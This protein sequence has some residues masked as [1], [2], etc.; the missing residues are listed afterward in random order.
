MEADM[1]DA[2]EKQEKGGSLMFVGMALWV[3][4][5]LVMYFMPAG[6]QFGSNG[7]FAAI[8]LLLAFGGAV[9]MFRGWRMRRG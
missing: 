5:L 2:E 8:L 7:L 1:V 4:G 6:V 3:A 9:L